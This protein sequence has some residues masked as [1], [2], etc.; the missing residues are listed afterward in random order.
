M[1]IINRVKRWLYDLSKLS[2]P[3][4]VASF[5]DSLVLNSL[6]VPVI[7]PVVK[8]GKWIRWMWGLSEA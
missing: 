6:N 1:G 7:S 8:R 5:V 4:K 2:V 3:G